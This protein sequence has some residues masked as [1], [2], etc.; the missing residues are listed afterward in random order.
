MS[1]A[2]LREA[3]HDPAIYPDLTTEVAVCETHIIRDCHGDLRAEHIYRKE[4]PEKLQ[5]I[6]CIEFNPEFRYIDV[7]AEVA[8]LA[9]DL[10]RLGVLEMAHRC[11]RGY[12][13]ATGDTGWYRL[14]DFYRCYRAYGRGK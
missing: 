2:A 13:Q 10:D 1:S 6:D 11:V 8:F 4:K 5:I 9:M 7:A 12:V 14:L 3:L